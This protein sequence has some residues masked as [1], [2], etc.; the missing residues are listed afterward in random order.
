[1][2]AASPKYGTAPVAAFLV[3]T[4]FLGSYPHRQESAQDVLCRRCNMNMTYG[5]R[6]PSE[7]NIRSEASLPARCRGKFQN[8]QG[9]HRMS[10]DIRAQPP[11]PHLCATYDIMCGTRPASFPCI[12]ICPLLKPPK[13]WHGWQRLA[14]WYANNKVGAE[15]GFLKRSLTCSS[16]PL[17]AS[18]P[19][20]VPGG[21]VVLTQTWHRS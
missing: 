2:V 21:L 19:H 10:S 8:R 6:P 11:L 14:V 5:R 7:F 12:L 4:S 9:P 16:L 3:D 13:S 17:P 18:L 1:M 15:L 20:R